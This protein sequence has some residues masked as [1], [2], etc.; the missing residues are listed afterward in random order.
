MTTA[1]TRL[2]DLPYTII[3]QLRRQ[4]RLRHYSARTEETYVAWTRRF[5][6]FS[7]MR[8]PRVL[9]PD[10]VRAFLSD[11]ATRVGV[12]ASTQ[13][14][15][16]AAL[17]FLYRDVLRMGLPWLDGIAHAKRPAR[18]PVVLTRTEVAK[19]IGGMSG[20][21]KLIAS[22]MYAGGLRLMEGVSLRVKDVDFESR[23]ITVRS[24]KGARD[25]ITVL[26]ESHVRPLKAHLA[27]VERI[28]QVDIR[29]RNFAIPLP[30]GFAGKAPS[31]ARSWE[32]YW[33]FPGRRS[34]LSGSGEVRQRF[35][36]H[37]TVVQRAVSHAARAMRL[38][39]RVTTHA[40]RHSFATHLLEAGADIRTIQEL[41]GHR[42]VSTTMIYTHVLNRGGRGVKSPADF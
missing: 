35:H 17:L 11:L 36:I 12:S 9:Q 23:S 1:A 16:L 38:G 3:G 8:H 37:A 33:V 4:I 25:R 27:E 41:L 13:N 28:W 22:V 40:F 6:R 21:P 42:D 20:M 30:D 7:D 26:A 39:K 29:D 5:V 31:A 14:Q 10:D 15:A 24:G 18:L 34:H 2:D 19:V 32:W